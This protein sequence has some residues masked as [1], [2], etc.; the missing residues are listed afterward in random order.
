MFRRKRC[1][2]VFQQIC[3]NYQAGF[4][5]AVLEQSLVTEG[6]DVKAVL[7]YKT[8]RSRLPQPEFFPTKVF[9]LFDPLLLKK[10]LE[11]IQAD[12]ENAA[13]AK[14]FGRKPQFQVVVN[15]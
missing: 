2:K 15:L 13:L 1:K 5:T 14:A 7:I 8:A 10:S 4:S 11:D 3:C 9:K 6:R 12:E